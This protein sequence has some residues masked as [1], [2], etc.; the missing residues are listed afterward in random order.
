MNIE[1]PPSDPVT[2]EEREKWLQK[3]E[4][5]GKTRRLID[6]IE[7]L[8]KD[9]EALVQNTLNWSGRCWR[10]ED[11]LRKAEAERD[12]LVSFLQDHNFLPCD[13]TGDC[14]LDSDP[15]GSLCRNGSDYLERNCWRE[16]AR[17]EAER[18]E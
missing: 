2:K 13:E 12:A 8:E 17:N 9:Q 1:I 15:D 7:R 14:H 11:S 3:A 5:G 10:A 18:E 16:W 6:H 4:Y